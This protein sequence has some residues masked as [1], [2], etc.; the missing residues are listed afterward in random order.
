LHLVQRA[1]ESEPSSTPDKYKAV[2]YFLNA[3]E[4][5][6]NVPEYLYWERSPDGTSDAL[7]DFLRMVRSTEPCLGRIAEIANAYKHCVRTNGRR[8]GSAL[9]ARD[10]ATGVVSGSVSVKEGQLSVQIEH[11]FDGIK[12]EHHT[13]LEEGWR[14]WIDYLNRQSEI[15]NDG[16]VQRRPQQ[17][18]QPSST[19][20][21]GT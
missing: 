16:A 8:S 7:K 15:L 14:F 18:A 6:N 2:R 21:G 12:P 13:A 20:G 10:L 3:V 11:R 17:A 1:T 19:Q 5:M 9:T 4:S